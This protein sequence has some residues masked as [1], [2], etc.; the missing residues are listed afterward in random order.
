MVDIKKANCFDYVGFVLSSLILLF[1]IVVT[2]YAIWENKT[3]FW[4]EVPG[5]A[6]L[7]IFVVL[8]FALGVV[9]G[10]QIALVELKRQHPDAYRHSHPRAFYLG[11]L[12]NRGDNV[13]RFLMGRQVYV[14]VIVFLSAKLTTI[15]RKPGDTFLFPVPEWVDA[16][17]FQTGFLTCIVVVIISQLM[18]QIVAAKYPVHFLQFWLMK[19]AYYACIAVELT[20]ITHACWLLSSLMS[21][22]TG[23]RDDE[24]DINPAGYE[25]DLSEAVEGVNYALDLAIMENGLST[26]PEQNVFSR[27]TELVEFVNKSLDL[28]T[29]HIIRNYLDAH[30]EKYSKFPSV[31]G[32]RMYSAPQQLAEEL[33][34][35]GHD[36]PSFLTDIS[37]PIHVPP[38]IVAFELICRNRQLVHEIRTL[39]RQLKLTFER[40]ARAEADADS[41]TQSTTVN[42][43]V[44]MTDDEGSPPRISTVHLPFIYANSSTNQTIINFPSL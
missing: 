5:W 33:K 3:M 37:D 15:Y 25:L 30:P 43:D 16:V 6:A 34:E 36:V 29:I 4:S 12:A 8:L 27:Y 17:F 38:H 41:G 40:V 21:W 23:M 9:E 26:Y 10:L 11:Q 31:H 19:P 42:G 44:D 28:D 24:V 18:P 39:K 13:E 35:A 2:G 20:G 1:S 32:N 22:L 7:I 14:V